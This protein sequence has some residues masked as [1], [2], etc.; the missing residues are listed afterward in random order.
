MRTRIHAIVEAPVSLILF[1]QTE[2]LF[3]IFIK[4]ECLEIGI[5]VFIVQKDLKSVLGD[6]MN[7]SHI[8]R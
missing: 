6:V 2:G 8:G 4:P 1:V 7:R 5:Q 3:H